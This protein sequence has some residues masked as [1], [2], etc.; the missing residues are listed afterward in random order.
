MSNNP[1]VLPDSEY[2]RDF[3]FISGYKSDAARY[4]QLQTGRPLDEC[5]AFVESQ[6]ASDGPTP[7]VD[8]K[9]LILVQNKVQDREKSESTFLTFLGRVRKHNLRLSPSMAAYLPE[10]VR[11]STHSVYIAEAVKKRKT[12]KG[13]MF[14]AEQE[15][16]LELAMVKKGEQNNLKLNNNSYSGATVSVATI[17]HYKSTHSSLT[18]TCR[19]AAS[20]ANAANE[21]FLAG[22]RH[23]YTAEI[24]KA[25]IL[26]IIRNSDLDLIDRTCQLFGLKYPTPDDVMDCITYSTNLY[27][28]A[29]K[30]IEDIRRMVTNITPVERAAFMYVGDLHH[31]HKLNPAFVCEFLT[32]LATP[33]NYTDPVDDAAYK[34]TDDDVKLLANFLCYDAVKGRNNKQLGEQAPEVLTLL[35]ATTARTLR[36][37]GKYDLLLKSL[38]LSKN[39]PSSIHALP[40]VY[41]RAA[42]I[43]DT[44]STMFTMQEWVRNVFGDIVFT[45]QSRQ[46]VFGIVFVVS[47]IMIHV[48]AR[49]S[50]NMGVAKDKLRL[51]AMKNEYYFEVMMMTSRSK[52]YNA[53]QDAQEGLMFFKPDDIT[54]VMEMRAKMETKGVG[55]RDSKVPPAINKAAKDLMSWIIAQIKAGEMISVAKVL[56]DVAN[57]ERSIIKSIEEGGYE[58]M[59]TAQIK[60]QA[61][62]KNP[63]SHL[64]KQYELWRDVFSHHCGAVP[65]LPY[66]CVK[67]S[68]V[69]SN[70]TEVEAWCDRMGNDMLGS[71]LKAWLLEN[72]KKD[73]NTLMIP[74]TA[75]EE[76]GIPKEIVAGLDIRKI[77]AN[78]M[79][80]FYLI[81]ESLG[82]FIQDKN[83][84][85]LISDLY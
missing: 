60:A 35:K 39:M 54:K 85:I 21:K 7:L 32:D 19:V 59:T 76:N 52:H 58:Y 40:T 70:R 53:S 48:L 30:H 33:G 26:A 2:E 47:E 62:Y 5:R 77:I 78:T 14:V 82:F 27:W 45:E 68:L 31:L 83:N 13:E 4:L 44:D 23:Y 36:V 57:L 11:Q 42:I 67:V 9:A 10:S 72:R 37:L 15:G 64:Y 74:F 29:E 79:G 20:Y 49:Q 3:D 6:V 41:R 81:L 61:D 46:L 51:L 38:W 84:T 80:S 28:H 75:V 73:V 17:L 65:P 16:K 18:S 71:R 1:F 69:A 25:N 34:A 63:D 8:P 56:L 50:A 24:T 22:N 66:T 55:L 12:V 43:S